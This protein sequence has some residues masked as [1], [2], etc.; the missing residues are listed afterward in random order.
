MGMG[1]YFHLVKNDPLQKSVNH[2][3]KH[4]G[5]FQDIVQKSLPLMRLR[6]ALNYLQ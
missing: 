6:A 4:K 2:E 3:S 1:P 5:I